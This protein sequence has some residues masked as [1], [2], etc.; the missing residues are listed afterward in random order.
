MREY[1]QKVEHRTRTD[2]HKPVCEFRIRPVFRS[3]ARNHCLRQIF[4]PSKS[5]VL[6]S[7]NLWLKTL[8]LRGLRGKSIMKQFISVLMFTATA[9]LAL[10]SET[11]IELGQIAMN[12]PVRQSVTFKNTDPSNAVRIEKVETSCECLSVLNYPAEVAPLSSHFYCSSC[13][14]I[15]MFTG[16][17]PDC[18][19]HTIKS[20]PVSMRRKP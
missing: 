8:C 6:I 13:F 4:C 3:V 2:I 5:F 15:T 17:E 12:T 14:L 9:S 19:I 11:K 7:V 10:A 16:L 20:E 1:G 18:F